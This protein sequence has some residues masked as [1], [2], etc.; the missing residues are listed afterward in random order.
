LQLTCENFLLRNIDSG[1]ERREARP[2]PPESEEIIKA[3]Q[4][5]V[6]NTLETI[7]LVD[8]EDYIRELVGAILSIEG[9][10]VIEAGSG[11]Q[12][13]KVAQEFDGKIHL[14]LTDVVMSPMSGSELVKQIT[15]VRQDMKILYISGF[16]DDAI[17]QFG[18]HQSQVSFLAKPFTPKVLVQKIRSILDMVPA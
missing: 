18:I 12:A 7:L 10:N 3:K 8:D 16:P 1:P 17:V 11:P 5:D 6:A 9:Y 2:V 4:R 14:L 13:L 15:P